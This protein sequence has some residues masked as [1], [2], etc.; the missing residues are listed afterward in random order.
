MNTSQLELGGEPQPALQNS[1]TVP[2]MRASSVRVAAVVNSLPRW[3]L[4]TRCDLQGFL[5]SILQSPRI[6]HSDATMPAGASLWPIPVP[7]PEAFCS[8]AQSSR[9]GLWRKRLLS[10]QI[11]VLDWFVLGSP[12]VAPKS[13]RLGAKLT[14]KQW[15]VVSTLRHSNWDSN[16]IEF[17]AD[18]MGRSASKVEGYEDAL[19]ALHRAMACDGMEQSFYF[20]H[21]VTKPEFDT[22]SP[23]LS[24]TAVGSLPKM[25][26]SPAKPIVA[27]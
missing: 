6:A 21:S 27:D 18:L 19:S 12:R 3:L 24:G 13:L 10:L 5:R 20:G 1:A 25:N 7:Y 26:A 22:N 14:A 23:L 15:T 2:G 8:S 16:S 11:V 4:Q 9:A 17:I